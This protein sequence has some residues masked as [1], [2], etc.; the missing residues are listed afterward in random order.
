MNQPGR[1]ISLFPFL[2]TAMSPSSDL[3]TDDPALYTLVH[4]EEFEVGVNGFL[5]SELPLARLSDAYYEPWESL[6][7]QLPALLKTQ[8]LRP[9]IQSLP[10]LGVNRLRTL[11][12]WRRAYVI[13][14]FLAH[15]YIW[16]GDRPS[17]V[18]MAIFLVLD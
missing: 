2:P 5:P 6:I 11:P 1:P 9:A 14:G 13:L 15:G 12:E 4:L 3:L 7:Y 8:T 17:E 10:V 18:C 16:G